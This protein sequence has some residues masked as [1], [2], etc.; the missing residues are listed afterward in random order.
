MALDEFVAELDQL[1]EA[2]AESFSLASDA[3]MLE[4]L[5]VSL[6]AQELKT[7]VPISARRLDEH[8]ARVQG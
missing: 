5:R 4:E 7:A 1:A 6:F 3:S 2:A 8:W